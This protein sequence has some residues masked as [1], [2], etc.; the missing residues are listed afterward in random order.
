MGSREIKRRKKRFVAWHRHSSVYENKNSCR[1][2][3]LQEFRHFPSSGDR[4]RTNWSLAGKEQLKVNR[5]KVLILHWSVFGNEIK[6][7]RDEV[8]IKVLDD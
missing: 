4:H 2:F 1:K 8:L 5:L 6:R 7:K 3:L